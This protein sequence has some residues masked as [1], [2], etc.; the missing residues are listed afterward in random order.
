MPANVCGVTSVQLTYADPLGVIKGRIALSEVEQIYGV[1]V[2]DCSIVSARSR[3]EPRVEVQM[4]AG[5]LYKLK[6]VKTNELEQ[7]ASQHRPCIG[8]V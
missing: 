4:K 5:R 3:L 1:L 6:S 8:L 2:R 7:A